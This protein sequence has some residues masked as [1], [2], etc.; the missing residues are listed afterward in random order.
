MFNSS[1]VA[2]G[3]EECKGFLNRNNSFPEISPRQNGF[4]FVFLLNQSKNI[5]VNPSKLKKMK[6]Y[7]LLITLL[8]FGCQEKSAN[9]EQQR[10]FR[11]F[12]AKGDSLL[13]E[14]KFVEARETYKIAKEL[15]ADDNS[16][17]IIS[18]KLNVLNRLENAKVEK[19]NNIEDKL[20]YLLGKHRFG[21]QFIWDGYG[22]SEF[23]QS[24]NKVFFTGE[25]YS[26]DRSDYLVLTGEVKNVGQNEFFIDGKMKINITSCCGKKEMEGL[27]KFLK[28][29]SRTYWRMQNPEREMLCGR[30]TCHYY[31]DIF[32]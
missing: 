23:Y 26:N 12:L 31:I 2:Y 6:Y 15:A 32:E 3:R 30:Q 13:Y 14:K 22:T 25:Q 24:S 27:F 9:A 16:S 21:V 8:V 5:L 10:L 11:S 29:G 28:T 19:T 7:L 4:F 1:K 17:E 20:S 18:E